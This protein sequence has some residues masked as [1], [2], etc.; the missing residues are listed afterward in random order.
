VSLESRIAGV[1]EQWCGRRP[2][3]L[4]ENLEDLWVETAPNSSHSSLAFDPD[5]ITSIL[6]ELRAKFGS[7]PLRLEDFQSSGK[8]KTVQHLVD[9]AAF[10]A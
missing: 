8:I 7:M 10:F 3:R 5:G 6:Q 4:S 1:V 2:E 9:E